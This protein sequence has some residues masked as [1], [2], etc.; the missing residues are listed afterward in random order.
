MLKQLSNVGPTERFGLP[1][2]PSTSLQAT[3]EN[4][5]HFVLS[6]PSI[7]LGLLPF[8]LP[9]PPLSVRQSSSPVKGRECVR[10][11]LVVRS[12]TYGHVTSLANC[13]LHLIS[14][15]GQT[16]ASPSSHPAPTPLLSSPLSFPV[17]TPL[18]MCEYVRNYVVSRAGA[19]T[20]PPSS[21][22]TP[23]F[24]FSNER[25]TFPHSSLY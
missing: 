9:P 18:G 7:V 3:T 24:A 1:F 13:H 12:S 21:P 4:P 10:S 17:S 5:P 16:L 19:V 8:L 14:G 15:L 23:H 22:S 6:S 11:L 25:W 2:R 20:L